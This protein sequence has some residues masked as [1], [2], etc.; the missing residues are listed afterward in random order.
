MLTYHRLCLGFEESMKFKKVRMA[1]NQ[2]E[3]LGVRVC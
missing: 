3:S 1:D 2:S